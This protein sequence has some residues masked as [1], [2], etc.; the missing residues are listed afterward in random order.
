[1]DTGL[2]L[3][4]SEET[5]PEILEKLAAPPFENLEIFV[6]ELKPEEG[7]VFGQLRSANVWRFLGLLEEPNEENAPEPTNNKK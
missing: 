4:K 6:A 7:N 2:Y 3:V 1:M 5:S